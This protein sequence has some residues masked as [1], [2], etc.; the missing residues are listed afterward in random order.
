MP[1]TRS[2]ARESTFGITA[3]S[4]A[5]VTASNGGLGNETGKQ[6]WQ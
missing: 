4:G 3:R 6:P 5:I 2:E 1:G